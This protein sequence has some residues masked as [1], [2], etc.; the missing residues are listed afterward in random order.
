MVKGKRL[1]VPMFEIYSNPTIKI[2]TIKIADLGCLR[3][4]TIRGFTII[5]RQRNLIIKNKKHVVKNS[6]DDRWTIKNIG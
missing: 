6:I 4:F 3:G 1:T 5:D 2:P